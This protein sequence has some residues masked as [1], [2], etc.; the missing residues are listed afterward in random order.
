[1]AGNTQSVCWRILLLTLLLALSACSMHLKALPGAI[2]DAPSTAIASSEWTVIAAGL[3]WREISHD[4]DQ[5]AQL[6]L[7]R[8]DPERYFFRAK[9][10][11]GAPH[12]LA[13]WRAREPE[14]AAIVNANFFDPSYQALGL[15]IS[16]GEAYGS[17]Y[18]ERGGSFLVNQSR[19]AVRANSSMSHRELASAQQAVQGFP[20]LVEKGEQAY[21]GQATQQRA[22]RTAIAED[23][24]GNILIISAPLLGPTLR[25]LSAF[26]A[27]SDL[28]IETA[29]NL[30]GGGSTLMAVRDIDYFQPSFD[31]VPAILAVYKG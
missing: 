16:D 22:R 25:D 1:M 20:L 10:S 31:A 23:A 13:Q 21:F 4:N 27:G 30:D 28:E 2:A 8:I 9:Y 15:V 19:A 6:K 18:L 26:L 17:P 3:E 29:F 5:L 7:L 12:S 24:A 11:P 14:A